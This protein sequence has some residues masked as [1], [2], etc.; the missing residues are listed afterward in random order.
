MNLC[1]RSDFWWKL[2]WSKMRFLKKINGNT[3]VSRN[4]HMVLLLAKMALCSSIVILMKCYS[5]PL[6]SP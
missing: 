4:M 1:S 5:D 3:L 6:P 2:N